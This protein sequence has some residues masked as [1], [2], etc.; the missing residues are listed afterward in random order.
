MSFCLWFWSY[1]FFQADKKQRYKVWED[2][3]NRRRYLNVLHLQCLCL[4]KLYTVYVVVTASV[5]LMVAG[6]VPL[7]V[8]DLMLTELHHSQVENRI[9]AV[10]KLVIK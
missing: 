10:K 9:A 6:Q 3:S 2:N 1:P 4:G 8:Q 5:L 7:C